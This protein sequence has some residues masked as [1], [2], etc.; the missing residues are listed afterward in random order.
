MDGRVRYELPMAVQVEPVAFLPQRLATDAERFGELGLA[1]GAL[2][3]AHEADEVVLQ[4]EQAVLPR[5]RR[6]RAGLE[7]EQLARQRPALA[8]DDGPLERILQLAHIPRPVI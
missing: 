1:H 3:V 8:Q 7:R 6:R 5:R 2:V 4:G